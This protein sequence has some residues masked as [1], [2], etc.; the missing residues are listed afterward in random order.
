LRRARLCAAR[1]AQV[2]MAGCLMSASSCK[3]AF[4]DGG[5]KVLP[6][7]APGDELAR[8][9]LPAIRL[10]KNE[11][12]AWRFYVDDQELPVRGAGGAVAPG[13]LEGLK[14]AGG[15]CVR[16]WGIET[17]EETSAGGERFIDRAHRL[18]LMVVPGIWLQHERHGFDYADPKVIERQR[19]RVLESV[20]TYKDHPAVL[21]WGL[22]NEM[23]GPSSP[24]GSVPVW[25][26][27][28]H[29]A[30]LVKE[31][32][33]RHPVM[34]VV[35]FHPAKVESV[36]RYCP[37]IDILGVNS[38]GA[39]AGAGGAL[40][41]A[42]WSKPFAVTEFGVR[43][44]WEVETT[45]W[46]APY[47]PTS[48]EKARTYYATHKLVFERNEG[49]ELCL[50]TFAFLWGWKQERTATWFGMFLPSLEKLPQVDAM[51]RAWT[52]HWPENRC[53]KLLGL[54]SA[55][56]GK[57]VKPGQTL[58]AMVEVEDP[59]GDELVYRWK[60]VAESTAASEGGDAEDAPPEYPELVQQNNG[61]EC[62]FRSPSSP[63]NYRL[64][65][66][67]RDSHGGGATANFPFRVES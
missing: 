45:A 15:N 5:S 61:P 65:L 14:E 55:A 31:E 38:Y 44:F 47:E 67:V 43:G 54:S 7:T 30:R 2:L 46:G 41:A 16:T 18:G 59:E 23:E 20:R 62:V 51:T 12:G 40:K 56:H 60:V 28:E 27:V 9:R 22:G 42:G 52:G 32:D 57:V 63:G 25:Q 29:L 10:G 35:A 66:T 3:D 26:E 49:K 53:P 33:P 34:T 21:A 36:M 24:T 8:P 58:R 1:L 50:G 64:F 11:E 39:A 48:H 37:S 6:E 13:L 17:L 19:A 4:E